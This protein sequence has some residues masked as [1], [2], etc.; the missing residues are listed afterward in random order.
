VSGT[1]FVVVSDTAHL[2]DVPGRKL[3]EGC[4]R[5]GDG[6]LVRRNGPVRFDELSRWFDEGAPVSVMTRVEGAWPTRR[7]AKAWIR[8]RR[9]QANQRPRV[10]PASVGGAA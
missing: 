9:W 8:R 7:Q 2:L 6:D 10:E 5:N 3:P 4:K 1:V